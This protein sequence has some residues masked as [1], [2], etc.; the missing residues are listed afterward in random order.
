MEKA[1]AIW[2]MEIIR[3]TLLGIYVNQVTCV[4]S[5]VKSAAKTST[6]QNQ[7]DT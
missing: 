1:P 3:V 7:E 4:P 5:I 6:K 2:A